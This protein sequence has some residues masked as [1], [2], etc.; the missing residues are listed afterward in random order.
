MGLHCLDNFF[1]L[2][3]KAEVD[4]IPLLKIVDVHEENFLFIAQRIGFVT[5]SAHAVRL[6]LLLLLEGGKP[7]WVVVWATRSGRGVVC[8]EDVFVRA[9]AE[10]LLTFHSD[11]LLQDLKALFLCER[12][13]F[14]CEIWMASC[15]FVFLRCIFITRGGSRGLVVLVLAGGLCLCAIEFTVFAF[16][17]SIATI[18]RVTA[19][20]FVSNRLR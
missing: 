1:F 14:R 6:R 8:Q 18:P 9:L 7:W 13:S 19:L 10:H 3:S 12:C 15:R 2:R 20:G 5:S 17:L 11:D 4:S 16:T